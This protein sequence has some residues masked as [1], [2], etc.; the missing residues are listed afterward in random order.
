LRLSIM[1]GA[2][3]RL[4][5]VRAPQPVGD[6]HPAAVGQDEP[7]F[8]S[9]LR[10]LRRRARMTQ[11]VL[12]ERAGV[13]VATIGALEEDRRRRPY[14]HTVAA[15][16]D[17]LGL[18]ADERAALEAVVPLHPRTLELP[19]NGG[20]LEDTAHGT[21]EPARAPTLPELPTPLTPLVGR[22]ADV[23]VATERLRQRARLLTLTGPGGVGKTRLA[24][25]IAA[26][27]RAHFPD[28]VAF[29]PLAPLADAGLVPP[30]GRGTGCEAGSE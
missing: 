4:R 21:D 9:L 2:A 24:L 10:S 28:G 20:T 27:A 26:E 30:T 8:G 15:L 3:G 17:A 25:Q 16:A 6:S 22:D 12:A 13:S 11:G 7:S 18:E 23:A 19:S 1:A 14:P 5:P 29:V